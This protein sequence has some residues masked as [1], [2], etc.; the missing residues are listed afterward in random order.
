MVSKWTKPM[1]DALKRLAGHRS[2]HEVWMDF[3]V[4]G[5][6][7]LSKIYP[8][9]QLKDAHTRIADKYSSD[10]MESMAELMGC[11]IAAFEENP[12]QDFLGSMYME[13]GIGNKKDGQ[14]FTPYVVCKA[15]A[16][17]QISKDAVD[18]AI[19]ERGYITLNDPACGGGAT[20]IAGANRLKELGIDYQNFAW[21][22]AQDLNLETACMCYIQLSLLGCA[23]VVIVGDTITQERRQEL[24]L[25]MNLI[26]PWWTARWM[27]GETP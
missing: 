15:M 5:A 6:S 13:L 8:N 24:M 1:Q 21:F 16:D 12:N 14:F 4:Y 3:A 22:E 26:S 27:K 18:D 17:A 23:G 25:P 7:E 9:N 11:T 19:K 10:G 20:L 2:Y